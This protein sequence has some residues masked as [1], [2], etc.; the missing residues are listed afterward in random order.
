DL[1][2]GT[3]TAAHLSDRSSRL[4]A[5]DGQRTA[6]QNQSAATPEA[7]SAQLAGLG[8][9]DDEAHQTGV[10]FDALNA[11]EYR[12]RAVGSIYQAIMRRAGTAAELQYWVSVPKPYTSQPLDLG[13]IAEMMLS[14]LE[15]RK[16]AQGSMA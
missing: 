10:L 11:D 1:L 15:Y 8:A 12:Q 5:L 13:T 6:A 2:G 9:L 4:A 16:N 3:A 14:S 7:Y